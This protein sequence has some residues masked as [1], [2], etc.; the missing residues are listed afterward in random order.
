[1]ADQTHETKIV[2]NGDASVAVNALKLVQTNV[3]RVI[4]TIKGAFSVLGRINWVIGGIQTLI[5][6][7]K[8]AH[9][10]M[11]RAATAAREL[12][13]ELARTK[14]EN[15]VAHAA[16]SYE[17]LTKQIAEANRLEKERN[18]ILAQRRKYERDVEDANLERS[19]QIEI[20]GLDPNAKDYSERKKEIERRYEVSASDA[21]AARAGD[22]VKAQAAS[23][24]READRKESEANSMRKELDKQD[25]VVSAAQEKSWAAAMKARRGGDDEK[26]AARKADEEFKRQF[27]KAKKI[28]DEIDA[29]MREA[30]S[31]RNKAAEL[32]GGNVAAN[33][34]NEA[35]KQRIENEA[36][37]EAAEKK[38][39]ADEEEK[40]KA[41][42]ET[43]DKKKRDQNLE[44]AQLARKKQEDLAALDPNDPNYARRKKEI[45]ETYEIKAAELKRDRATNDEDRQ[46]ADTEREAIGMRQE[47]ERRENEA[48]RAAAYSGKLA[49]L[50]DSSRPKDRLTAMGLGSGGTVDRTAQEQAQNVKTLVQLV[51]EEIAAIRANNNGNVAV[52]AP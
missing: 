34:L 35:N 31:I 37:A 39:K 6:W 20:A 47:R 43:E 18:D 46:A 42:K 38:R 40:R 52:Y 25:A 48:E 41:D 16:A 15:Q 36:K 1:M 22:D 3:N 2:I 33:I 27:D 13:E 24:Y 10:W 29:V 14:Y 17:K 28:R 51:K 32:T 12:R 44:D 9:D 7:T 45:E 21:K 23:L 4:G 30:Q 26:E 50:S 8:K 49:D 5:E 19:K 11:N